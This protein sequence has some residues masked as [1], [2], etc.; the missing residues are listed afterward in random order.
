MTFKSFKLIIIV[1]LILII[2]FFVIKYDKKEHLINNSEV[3]KSFQTLA[4]LLS[5]N[6]LTIKP[7]DANTDIT[8]ILENIAIN[9]DATGK[10]QGYLPSNIVYDNGKYRDVNNR[11]TINPDGTFSSTDFVFQEGLIKNINNTVLYDPNTKKLKYNKV[12][13]DGINNKLEENNNKYY[14]NQEGDINAEGINYLYDNN[15]FN[16]PFISYDINTKVLKQ[17]NNLFT[18][19]NIGNLNTGGI[20]YE[21]GTGNVTIKDLIYNKN[22]DTITKGSEFVYDA[23][24]NL[25][26]NDGNL[27]YT[28]DGTIKKNNRYEINKDG[29]LTANKLSVDDDKIIAGNLAYDLNKQ[30]E[31]I[32]GNDIMYDFNDKIIKKLDDSVIINK[33]GKIMAK[34][35]EDG[36]DFTY[37]VTG[38]IKARDLLYKPNNEIS[39]RGLVYKPNNEITA[40]DLVYKSSGELTA[41]D[42]VYSPNGD[43]IAKDILYQNNIIKNKDNS[44]EYNNTTKTF[45]ADYLGKNANGTNKYNFNMDNTGNVKVYPNATNTAYDVNYNKGDN[46]TVKDLTYNLV[47][48]KIIKA[49]TN[50]FEYDMTNNKL[51]ALKDS[52]NKYNFIM[53]KGVIQAEYNPKTDKYYFNMN[54]KKIDIKPNTD[55]KNDVSIDTLDN[56]ILAMAGDS[57]DY[58]FIMENGKIKAN[59]N[60]VAKNYYFNLDGKTINIKPD[61]TGTKD[62]IYENNLLYNQNKTFKYDTAKNAVDVIGTSNTITRYMLDNNTGNYTVTVGTV[63]DISNN[64]IF[65]ATYTYNKFGELIDSPNFYDEVIIM[66]KAVD[67]SVYGPLHIRKVFFYDISGYTGLGDSVGTLIP[68]SDISGV[69]GE[70]MDNPAIETHPYYGPLNV[71]NLLAINNTITFSGHGNLKTKD[72]TIRIKFTRPRKLAS[73]RI[74]NRNDQEQRRIH[75]TIVYFRKNNITLAKINLDAPTINGNIN[76][77]NPNTKT[78]YMSIFPIYQQTNT[79]LSNRGITLHTRYKND[80]IEWLTNPGASIYRFFGTGFEKSTSVFRNSGSGDWAYAASPINYEFRPWIILPVPTIVGTLDQKDNYK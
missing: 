9:V 56:K 57:S 71:Q 75:K 16:T 54:G 66:K 35:N 48:N 65:P 46:I 38:D 67:V 47:T 26:M 62:L 18:I 14:I 49:G 39:A 43:I 61:G 10:I 2:L 77:T 7:I 50:Y 15:T 4:Q 8:K 20:I 19:D 44:F 22:T 76:I 64:E 30:D 23:D 21:E 78:D 27:L 25:S 17:K 60:T 36:Y 24:K 6:K 41:K 45:N 73:I 69:F 31:I 79:I 32:F 42:F 11:F 13:Y 58:N 29:L 28:V 51:Q 59:W 68:T 53:D 55:L 5:N 70:N 40:R 63:R 12:T 80:I 34:K 74:D 1:I 37:D 3:E 52:N 72:Q 33:E